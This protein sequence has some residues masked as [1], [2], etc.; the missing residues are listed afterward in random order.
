[1]DDAMQKGVNYPLGPLAWGRHIGFDRVAQVLHHLA[2]ACGEDR[3][4]TSLWLQR[5]VQAAQPLGK[6]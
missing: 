5:E 2:Q 3:Y 1:V 4:R 6:R